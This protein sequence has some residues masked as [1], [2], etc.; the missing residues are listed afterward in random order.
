MVNMYHELKSKIMNWQPSAS[1]ENL[2]IRAEFLQK[3]R[4]FFD[5]R[6]I[7]EVDTPVLS[8][9]AALDPYIQSMS[10]DGLDSYLQTSP[11]FCMKRLLAAG[12][13]PIYQ[14]GKV[15]RKGESGKKHNPEFTMLEW[16]RP[17][18]DLLEF[19]SEVDAL[20]Q[21]LLHCEPFEQVTY[22]E[23]FEEFCQINPHTATIERCIEVAS[24]IEGAPMAEALDKDGWLGFL[25][26]HLI[27][28]EIAEHKPIVVTEFPASQCALAK[29]IPGEPEKAARFEVFYKG[30]ELA[31]GY[32]ELIDSKEQRQRFLNDN[33]K[34]QELGIEILPI[35]ERF[36][37][38][39]DNMPTACGVAVGV[40]R[41]LQVLL[42]K[43]D[44]KD[45]LPFAW[46]NV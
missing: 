23:L 12:S 27:E 45:V 26:T 10:V 30:F 33:A 6:G 41:L 37:A 20:F 8:K 34:R 43:P 24:Q 39:L 11:E 28:P 4:T 1:I 19:I 14:M 13:G 21:H 7:Y 36:I 38:C 16:Y 18:I 17:R 5:V 46:D 9:S 3:I 25:Q 15:F 31:N 40:D 29:I 22:Q 44:I 2:K 35:D 42:N 32:D